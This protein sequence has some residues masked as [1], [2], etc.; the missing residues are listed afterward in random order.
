MVFNWKC[1]G[2]ATVVRWFFCSVFSCVRTVWIPVEMH[3]IYLAIMQRTTA[4]KPSV[5]YS[6]FI[7]CYSHAKSNKLNFLYI[8]LREVSR[9]SRPKRLHLICIVK[10]QSSAIFSS[11]KFNFSALVIDARLQCNSFIVRVISYSMRIVDIN[12]TRHTWS[13]A[14]IIQD[15]VHKQAIVTASESRI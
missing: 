3:V 9:Q 1:D 11:S 8:S 13:T 6:I 12:A 4:A 2:Y 15:C 7:A 14:I 10:L 5:G